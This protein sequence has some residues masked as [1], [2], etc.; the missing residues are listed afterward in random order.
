MYVNI[1]TSK[2]YLDKV[3]IENVGVVQDERFI[4]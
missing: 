4:S 2:S 1:L 3:F